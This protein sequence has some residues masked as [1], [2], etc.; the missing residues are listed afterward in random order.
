MKIVKLADL[1]EEGRVCTSIDLSNVEIVDI[2]DT[3]SVNSDVIRGR[4]EFNH[5]VGWANCDRWWIGGACGLRVTFEGGTTAEFTN[6][7]LDG[8]Y[9]NRD[10][11][12]AT[13][14]QLICLV[15]GNDDVIREPETDMPDIF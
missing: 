3:S 10:N 1:N 9:G 2:R 11:I 8:R 4:I 12:D 5:G 15:F 6:L 14:K 13:V 7:K